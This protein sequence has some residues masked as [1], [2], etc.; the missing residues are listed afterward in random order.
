LLTEERFFYWDMNLPG[1]PVC[2]VCKV[3]V[4]AQ[5][6]GMNAKGQPVIPANLLALQ[7]RIGER[8]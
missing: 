8:V 6:V 7:D 4:Q 5:F 1:C 2:P 3:E